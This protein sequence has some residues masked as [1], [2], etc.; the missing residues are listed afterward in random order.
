MLDEELFEAY[1]KFSMVPW[2]KGTLDPKIKELIYIAIG[3]INNT[4]I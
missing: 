3:C 4:F 1:L 2:K